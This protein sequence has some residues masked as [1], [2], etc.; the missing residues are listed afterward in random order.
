MPIAQSSSINQLI[1][2]NT[3]SDDLDFENLRLL[4]IELVQKYSASIWT[5]YN[6]HDPGVTILEALCFALTDLAYR[7]NFPISDILTKQNGTIDYND[8]SFYT[9]DQILATN[10]ANL[11]DLKK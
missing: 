1:E 5:D 9:I 8:Q 3:E 2:L 6:L 11:N 4:A 10:P 7:T